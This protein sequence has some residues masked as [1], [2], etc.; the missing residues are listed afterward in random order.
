M[1]RYPACRILAAAMLVASTPAALAAGKTQRV[2]VGSAGQQADSISEGPE[3]SGTGRYVAFESQATN[4]AAGTSE[5]FDQIY[6][7]DRRAGT[8]TLVS[9]SSAGAVGNGSSIGPVLARG[10][11]RVAFLSF[12]TNLVPNATT[13]RGV[14]LRDVAAGTTSLVSVGQHGEPARCEPSVCGPDAQ[15][16]GAAEAISAFGRF[17]VFT[18][19]ATNIVPGAGH[20]RIDLFVR[21]LQA[22][23]TTLESKGQGGAPANGDSRG[24]AITPDGRFLAFTSAASNLVPGDT[25]G[26]TDVFLRDR[27]AGKTVLVTVA[28]DGGPSRSFGELHGAAISDDGNLVAFSSDAS[29]LV[30]GDRNGTWDAFVRD[31]R[32]GTTERV[33]LAA[34]GS[35]ASSDVGLLGMSADGRYV[36]MTSAAANLAGDDSS[37]PGV[38]VRDRSTGVT[39]RVN[40]RSSGAPAKGGRQLYGADIS[41]DGRAVAFATDATNLVAGDTNGYPDVFVHVMPAAAR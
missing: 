16:Y 15:D 35:E 8:T 18:S 30:T 33:S 31:V 3:I 6:L 20:D 22:G 40:V 39:T 9:V 1:S 23:V 38:F 12:A 19:N 13:G 7:R 34:D 14:Y 25:N 36:L 21:D 5:G 29:D 10:G 27:Q 17:V 37:R 32:S 41:A 2:S 4:L 11:K 24:A 28:K 26:R